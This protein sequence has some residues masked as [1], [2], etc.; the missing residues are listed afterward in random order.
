[1]EYERLDELKAKAQEKRA[2]LPP[3]VYE[4]YL[5]DFAVTY[6]HESTAIEGN[7]LSLRETALLLVD[8]VSVGGKALRE[9]YEVTNHD[10]AFSRVL[11]LIHDGRPLEENTV[12]DLHEILMQNIFQGGA[13]RAHNVRITGASHRPPDPY[14]MREELKF[15]FAD[16]PEKRKLHPVDLAAWVHAEF[17]R[18]HPFA[19]GNG[20]TARLIMNYELMAGG[21]LP[22]SIRIENREEY[23]SALDLYAT[24]GDIKPFAAML[25]RLE[26][27]RLLDFLAI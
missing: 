23:Y 11:A 6:T 25:A 18:I 27:E 24:Q 15:F 5:R 26:E 8:G 10:K 4:K 22:I 1:M 19:D 3:A 2:E 21:F 20:R 12:K 9:I 14:K 7:T 17:V 13:Y 16:L